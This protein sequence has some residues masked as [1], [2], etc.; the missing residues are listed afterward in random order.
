MSPEELAKRKKQKEDLDALGAL[1]SFVSTNM[2]TI[3]AYCDNDS[4]MRLKAN[5]LD[6]RRLYEGATHQNVDLAQQLVNENSIHELDRSLPARTSAPPASPNLPIPRPDQYI[7]TPNVGDHIPYLPPPPPEKVYDPQ[8]EFSFID[9]LEKDVPVMK[10]L[11]D[12]LEKQSF[13]LEIIKK[14]LLQIEQNT[15]KRKYSKNDSKTNAR[16]SRG[17]KDTS[18][19]GTDLCVLGKTSTRLIGNEDETDDT[20][21]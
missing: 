4:K 20:R 21:E 16:K 9:K 8:L 2:N 15:R 19:T 5:K 6:P 12:I 3:D 1:A 10:K 18:N 17:S 11:F 13:N 14:T 7:P